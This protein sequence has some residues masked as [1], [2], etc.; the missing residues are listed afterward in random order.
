MCFK[1]VFLRFHDVFA[2]FVQL[3]VFTAKMTHTQDFGTKCGLFC[4]V[5]FVYVCVLN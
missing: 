4:I 2:V 3:I 1:A 5:C